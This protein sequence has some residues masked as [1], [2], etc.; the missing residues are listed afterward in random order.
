MR[1]EE[2]DLDNALVWI[3]DSKT[4][5]GLAEVPLTE[6]ALEAFRNQMAPAG[7]GVYLF[8]N[9]DNPCGHQRSFKKVWATTPAESGY[10][11]LPDLRSPVHLRDSSQR[12]WRR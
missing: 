11:L 8:P 1:K 6:L 2:V 12:G 9:P 7:P 5:S 10:T 4:P 3:P